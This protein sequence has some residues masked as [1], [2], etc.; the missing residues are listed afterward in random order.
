MDILNKKERYSAFLLFLLMFSV[1][2]GVLIFALFFDFRLPLKENEVLKSENE[3]IIGEFNFQKVFTERVEYISKLVDS[4]D[5]T[6]ERFP[7]LEQSINVELVDLKRKADSLE[8]SKLYENVII[9][10][11]KLVNS[12]KTSAQTNDSKSTIDRLTE[13]NKALEAKNNDLSIKLQICEQISKN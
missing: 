9:N 11:D 8:G 10:F 4:L 3:K 13:E 6:P 2:T 7:Y 5:K 1:T 12:K